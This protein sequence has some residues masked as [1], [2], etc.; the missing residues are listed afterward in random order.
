VTASTWLIVVPVPIRVAI[1]DDDVWIRRG[2]AQA[3]SEMAGVEVTAVLGH[4]EALER[5]A[6]WSAVDVA[7]VDAWDHRAGFDR[8]PG[9]AVVR[10]IRASEGGERVKV[11]VVSGHVVNDLLRLRMAE[12]GADLFYGHEEVADAASLGA[13]VRGEVPGRP[14]PGPPPAGGLHPDRALDWIRDQGVESAFVGAPQKLLGLSRRA[15][16]H[17]RREVG[18]RAGLSSA[19]SVAPWRLVSAFVDRARGAELRRDP[20]PS[21]RAERG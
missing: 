12:A 9:V 8:F 16:I 6:S 20:R 2:R 10:H 18:G 1:V 7:L 5:P 4:A 19:G 11:V 13:V 3:L 17:I 14:P 21:P 15:V